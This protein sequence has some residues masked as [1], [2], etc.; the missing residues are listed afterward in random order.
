M[1]RGRKVERTCHRNRK[2]KL[3]RPKRA[4]CRRKGE[5][6]CVENS[7]T[8]RDKTVKEEN[9]AAAKIQASF[10]GKQADMKSKSNVKVCRAMSDQ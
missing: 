7:K 1:Y 8:Y 2:I 5:E 4:Y 3:G 10:R 9:K 6:G